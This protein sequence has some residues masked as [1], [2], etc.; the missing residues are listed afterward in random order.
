MNLLG[1]VNAGYEIIE[2]GRETVVGYHKGKDEY[3]AWNYSTN[4]EDVNFYWGRY[5]GKEYAYQ[6]FDKKEAGQYS[7]N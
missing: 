4:G 7:G 1:T 3:V 6:C 2:Q 5:G